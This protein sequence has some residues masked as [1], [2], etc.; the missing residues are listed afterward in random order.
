MLN[1]LVAAPSP[2][3]IAAISLHSRVNHMHTALEPIVKVSLSTT[4]SEDLGLDDHGL[5]IERLCDLL[6]LLRGER[7]L[8]DGRGDAVLPSV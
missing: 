3:P 6:S 4:T 2:R 7:G 1:T 8:A 5:A